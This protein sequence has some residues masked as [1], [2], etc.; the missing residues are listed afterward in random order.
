[1]GVAENFET[2]YKKL[3]LSEDDERNKTIRFHSITKILG[4][5]TAYCFNITSF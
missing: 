4:R 3:N 1:M 5:L 2:F